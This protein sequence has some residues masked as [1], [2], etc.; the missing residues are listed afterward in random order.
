MF[1]RMYQTNK[2]LPFF[3][4]SVAVF[5]L[6]VICGAIFLVC[7]KGGFVNAFEFFSRYVMS[8]FGQV[9][10][11][12]LSENPYF[13][14]FPT[15]YL[16]LNFILMYPFALICKSAPE[17]TALDG[18]TINADGSYSYEELLNYN[19]GIVH[20]YQFWVAIILFF[21]VTL[22]AIGFILYKSK[23]WNR[24]EF[25]FFY[26]GLIVSGFVMIGI[27]RGS[28]VFLSVAFILLFI[29]YYKSEKRVFRELSLVF[30]AIAGVLK[31]YP[32]L[33]GVLLL[34]NKRLFDSVKVA[35]YVA[36]LSFLPFFIYDNP[37][38]TFKE[39]FSNM[40]TFVGEENRLG[41]AMNISVSSVVC[42][43]LGLFKVPVAVSNKIGLV[44]TGC[45][46]VA[47][48]IASLKTYGDFELY[49]LVS[50]G[51]LILPPV[52]YYYVSAFMICAIV[53]LEKTISNFTKPRKIFYLTFF[54]IM[55]FLP[56]S[57]LMW[58]IPQCAL[59]VVIIIWELV[60][61]FSKRKST[62]SID[63]EEN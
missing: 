33:F 8:D 6:V 48:L 9:M 36:I 50:V 13:S 22:T 51:V 42:W 47:L 15:M 21:A 61:V 7:T 40:F 20:T 24:F 56:L 26:A 3:A 19:V 34:K 37:I 52:S 14:N 31:I 54:A 1:K 43:I 30:L 29:K 41:N 16:P 32:L 39:F 23:T 38:A 49:M 53:P 10:Y 5:L 62:I 2:Y 63:T 60:R 12:T 44:L 57:A 55:S 59:M 46:F 4:I 58:F 27:F 35:L 25:A 28:N 18:I 45:L 17:F 11:F